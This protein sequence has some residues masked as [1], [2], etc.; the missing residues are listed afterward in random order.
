MKTVMI[1]RFEAFLSSMSDAELEA[2]WKEIRSEGSEGPTADEFVA[3][4]AF[5]AAATN[6][7]FSLSKATFVAERT[8]DAGKYNYAMAA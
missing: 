5:S 2:M 6:V 7:S 3:G 1:E 4:F 8:Y